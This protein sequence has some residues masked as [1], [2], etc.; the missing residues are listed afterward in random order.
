MFV[1]VDVGFDIS[2]A[3]SVSAPN[4]SYNL[5]LRMIPDSTMVNGTWVTWFDILSK[6]MR[7][8][9]GGREFFTIFLPLIATH[10]Y[11]R[12]P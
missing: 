4:Q 7:R 1:N 6:A 9:V 12:W 3:N 2:E 8:N 11:N 10:L 5:S